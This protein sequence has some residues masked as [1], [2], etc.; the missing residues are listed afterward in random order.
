M[1]RN[2]EVDKETKRKEESNRSTL[3]KFSLSL[4][5][6]EDLYLLITSFR[7]LLDTNDLKS[8]TYHML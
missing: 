4:F 6:A 3:F 8:I 5:L 7:L 1:V 2:M